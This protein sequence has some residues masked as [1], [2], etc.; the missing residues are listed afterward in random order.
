MASR[1][2]TDLDVYRLSESIADYVWRVAKDWSALDQKTVGLQ[3]IRAADSIG[4]NFAEGSGRGSYRDN[5]R[6]VRYARG[7]LYE[8][9]HWLRRANARRLLSLQDVQHLSALLDELAPRLNAYLNS[10]GRRMS[11]AK[12]E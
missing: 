4:A 5:R 11:S 10:I 7:S 6:F 8:T 1:A 3:L 2:F 12:N 9:H